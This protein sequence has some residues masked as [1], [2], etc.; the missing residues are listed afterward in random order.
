MRAAQ[1]ISERL[2]KPVYTVLVCRSATQ[3]SRLKKAGIRII[4]DKNRPEDFISYIMNADLVLSEDLFTSKLG[5]TIV[6]SADTVVISAFLGLEALAIY[7]NYY[8]IINAVMGFV[9]IVYSSITAGV[10]NSMIVYDTEKNYRDYRIFTFLACWITAFCVSCFSGLF[11]PFMKLWMGKELLLPYP[12]VILLCVYFWVYEY[13]MMA[14]VYKDAGGIWHEDRFR[15]LLSGLVNLSLNL[16]TVKL[17]GLYGIVLSTIISM[18]IISAPWITSNIFKL[19][20]KK[21]AKKYMNCM[22]FMFAVK[23]ERNS[24][25]CKAQSMYKV[26]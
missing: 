6:S 21:S 13:I 12:L 4:R 10:G 15:P 17:L 7:Q 18:V 16:L 22:F 24:L 8:Y 11:Q 23:R 14:S 9:A 19:I 25:V 1:K 3:I 20:F 26:L 5:F 2:H